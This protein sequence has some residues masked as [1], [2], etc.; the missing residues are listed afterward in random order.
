MRSC[1]L[2]PHATAKGMVNVVFI[3]VEMKI[4]YKQEFVLAVLHNPVSIKPLM[5]QCPPHLCLKKEKEMSGPQN[6]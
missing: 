3:D 6:N 2:A 4:E 1:W 5:E